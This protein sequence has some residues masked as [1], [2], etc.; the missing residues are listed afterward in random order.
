[1]KKVWYYYFEG[2][3]AVGPLEE[4]DIIERI[5]KSELG[6]YQLM[7]R[8]GETE[9]R[10]ALAFDEF[11]ILL[12]RA[13][14]TRGTSAEWIIL[15]K[16]GGQLMIESLGPYTSQEVRDKLM[17]GSLNYTD[18]AWKDGMHQWRR[19][20]T[21]KDFSLTE[22]P[23]IP[24]PPPLVEVSE[25]PPL[26]KKEVSTFVEV[27][28]KK[29][30]KPPPLE[31]KPREAHGDDLT[32]GTSTA[33]IDDIK[34]TLTAK[35]LD[36]SVETG[37]PV[38]YPEIQPVSARIEEPK[39][40]TKTGTLTSIEA[41]QKKQEKTL[42]ERLRER[43][44]ARKR[45]HERTHER[46]RAAREDHPAEEDHEP[47]EN[48]VSSHLIRIYNMRVPVPHNWRQILAV[49]VL[50]LVSWFKIFGP[51]PES[52]ETVPAPPPRIAPVPPPPMTQPQV[53]PPKE[54][55]GTEAAVPGINNSNPST[56]PAKPALP[57][58][59]ASHQ[60]KKPFRNHPATRLRVHAE[61]RNGE[62]EAVDIETDASPDQV[63]WIEIIG[64]AGMVS[65]RSHY[66]KK[67]K[68]TSSQPFEMRGELP[69]GYYR[70]H[71]S[72]ADIA[73]D[74]HFE[75]G[76][77]QKG[78]YDRLRVAR[79][80]SMYEFWSERKRLYLMTKQLS[81]VLT[82]AKPSSSE[83]NR[84]A[85]VQPAATVFYDL[86]QEFKDICAAAKKSE[87]APARE[88]L[89]SLESRVASLSVWK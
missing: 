54:A 9:W 59:N 56:R 80:H 10:P 55:G 60:R 70:L 51:A 24:T 67:W 47:K 53:Q 81:R 49:L 38:V 89:Q 69:A 65:D 19:V 42:E 25:P 29:Y 16:E 63:I 62:L 17:D 32:K 2:Q 78:F 18:Y 7:F 5:E 45:A 88:K 79:K 87:L 12:S 61:Q 6:P 36:P 22:K 71:A 58:E 77:H 27:V 4:E 3:R 14:A 50:V 75:I 26:T 46:V 74:E 35:V 84:L 1:M 34:G 68:W 73:S 37:P 28:E 41:K 72:T 23:S 48:T 64:S 13:K 31:P 30:E 40:V 83:L 86:W 82:A 44:E 43:R 57:V 21:L 15:K 20:G 76:T 8:D 52:M 66:Y 33:K 39:T 85:K 11:R